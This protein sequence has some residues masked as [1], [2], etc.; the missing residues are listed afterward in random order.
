MPAAETRI[1]VPQNAVDVAR[2]GA[3]KRR[4]CVLA[5]ATFFSLLTF[6][7]WSGAKP[8]K[9]GP[10]AVVHASDFQACP[11][12]LLVGAYVFELIAGDPGKGPDG[13][14]LRGSVNY[15]REV[16]IVDPDVPRD[17]KTETIVHELEH[18]AAQQSLQRT[19]DYFATHKYRDDQWIEATAPILTMALRRYPELLTCE[20]K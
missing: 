7:F 16:I 15:D 19:A 3:V 1:E 20:L 6:A 10:V 5:I 18:I 9:P 14:P 8:P 4:L 13:K 17:L 2:V 12:R 11:K